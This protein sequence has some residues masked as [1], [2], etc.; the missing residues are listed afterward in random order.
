[1]L[2]KDEKRPSLDAPRPKSIDRYSDVYEYEEKIE[3]SNQ[4][5]DSPAKEII[6]DFS[7]DKKFVQEIPDNINDS[8][9]SKT[10]TKLK[11]L[12]IV[13]GPESSV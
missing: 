7:S 10:Q 5:E 4:L 12:D 9:N 6:N 13:S 1:M 11:Q 3:E 8:P 2:V